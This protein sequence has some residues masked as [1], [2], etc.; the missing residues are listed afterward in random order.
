MEILILD[1]QLGWHTPIFRML[2]LGHSILAQTIDSQT[3]NW[4]S[5]NPKE[6]LFWWHQWSWWWQW[7]WF[8][9]LLL[10]IDH[11]RHKGKELCSVFS[12]FPSCEL[13][14][15][16]QTTTLRMNCLQTPN[17]ELLHKRLTASFYDLP[18]YVLLWGK[19]L[20]KQKKMK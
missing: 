15:N 11:T 10:N 8:K 20:S 4:K 3:C 16:R 14:K 17:L 18:P 9:P 13:Q 7:L 12:P 2:H 6:D 5:S 19:Y 1:L